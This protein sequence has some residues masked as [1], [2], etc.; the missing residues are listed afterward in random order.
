MNENYDNEKIIECMFDPV[1]SEI[2]SELENGE[3]N[4]NYL[5]EK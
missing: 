2:L 3:K 1:T 4:S 5:A